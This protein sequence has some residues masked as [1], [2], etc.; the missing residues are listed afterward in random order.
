MKGKKEGENECKK[1]EKYVRETMKGEKYEWSQEIKMKCSGHGLFRNVCA[2]EKA[3]YDPVSLKNGGK[4]MKFTLYCSDVRGLPSNCRY[5]NQHIIE[6]KDQLVQALATDNVSCQF[7]KNYRSKENIRNAD[8]VVLDYDNDHT[9]N[10]EEWLTPEM[11]VDSL[12]EVMLAIAP[13]RNNM[14]PKNGKTPR[15]KGHVI[16]PISPTEDAEVIATL[17]SQI[18]DLC[19]LFDPRCLDAPHFIFGCLMSPEDIVWQDGTMMIDEYLRMDDIT[20]NILEGSRNNSMYLYAVKRLK[21]YGNTE[22]TKKDFYQ[23]A[24]RCVPPLPEYELATIWISA[25]RFYETKIKADPSYVPP[26]KYQSGKRQKELTEKKDDWELPIPYGE[27]TTSPFPVDALPTEIAKYVKAVAESTQTPVDMAGTV[28]L[29]ILSVAMQGKYEIQGKADWQ[30]PLNLYTIVVAPPSDRKSAVSHMMVKPV[31][32][33]ETQYNLRNAA[34]FESNQMQ[35]RILLRRQKTI[36]EKISKGNA[37]PEEMERIG[38][39]ITTFR[40]EKKLQLYVDD[41]TTEKLVSIL[42]SNNGRGAILSSEAGIFDILSGTYSKNVNI[43]AFLKAYSGDTIRVDRINRESESVLKP[44]LTMLLM[45]QPEVISKVLGN[46]TF[47]GRGL[48]ARFLYAMPESQVGKRRFHTEIVSEELYRQYEQKI[49]NILESDY[50]EKP[51]IITLSSEAY[52]L[53][54]QFSEELEPKLVKELALMTDWAGK[55][56]GNVLR[57]AGLLCRAEVYR[58]YDFLEDPE[59]LEV[60]AETMEKA[61]RIGRYYLNHAMTAYDVLPEDSLYKGAD[62][63]LR[64]IVDKDLTSF[65]RRT[66]M[67]HC[68]R[69]KTSESIQPI[70]NFLEDYGYLLAVPQEYR[71][72]GRPPGPKYVVNPRFKEVFRPSAHTL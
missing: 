60:S 48:T 42:A 20:P 69:F 62:M 29:A 15:P 10:P 51:E 3:E 58:D 31:N 17:K 71:G 6:N 55:L 27:Y 30:E 34:R 54:K 21:R 5:P 13:S 33:Y 4:Q 2:K 68:R 64:T 52:Q 9:D 50:P 63:I 24:E 18:Y 7:E 35:K 37:E 65:D 72:T 22:E 41:V 70:L 66:I 38:Q 67:R 57:I 46:R 36:E 32:R 23:E 12:P 43:D 8:C 61:I 40:E 26:E 45:A 11:I 1:K 19:P 49:T 53:L 16:F 56:V 44:T 14:K 25:T 47:R 39:E 59:P 28:A